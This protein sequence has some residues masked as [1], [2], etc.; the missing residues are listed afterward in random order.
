MLGPLLF[1]IF[2]NDIG[3]S[4]ESI[5]K[6]FADD[7][8]MSLGLT[9]PDTRAEI[10]TC[11]L[12]KISDW[13][14]LWKVKFNEEKTELVNIK[15]DTKPIHQLTFGNVVLEDKPHHKHLG[16][17]LQNNCKWDE[18]ISNISSKVNMLIN[19]LRHFKY[20]PGRKA[21]E[22]MYKS[23]I[24]P[25]FDYA[26]IIWDNCTNTQSNMLEN[27]HLE[28]IRIITG[29]VRGT[30]HQKLY[31][32]SGF[33][34]L[35]ERR[36]RH[37]LIQ[38][39]KMINNTC[40]DY[41]SD[42]LPPLVSTTNPY[43]RRRPYERIIP[44]FRTELYRNS[45]FPSTTLLWNNLPVNIQE[46]SSLSEFK[47][48]LTNNDTKV[49]SYYYSGQ[50]MEQ[51]IHCRLRLQMSDLNFDLFNRHLTE[52]QSCA[53]GHPFETAEHFL[54][55]CPNYHDIRR[56]TLMQ[57]EDNYLDIQILLFGNRSLGT[58]QN[59][60]IFKKVHEFIRRTRRF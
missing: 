30:S 54:L 29:S 31:N 42:L 39:H 46:S 40:P 47:R 14:K 19:C 59:E 12:V 33:C 49:P 32:E 36:K 10:L 1:L 48:Y 53:C 51:I 28:A 57:I 3:H 41:L 23:F 8:S 2:I 45:F 4:I 38:F 16:I 55:L 24:L 20:K 11:D 44:S 18:H 27:L 5:I 37:K 21:L 43:H 17:T 52:N 25:L 50:R 58:H 35:K 13:A 15:R 34:T 7:T 56:D 60:F 9:N 6:L 22:I 26:D